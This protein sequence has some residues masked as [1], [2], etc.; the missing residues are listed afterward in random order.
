MVYVCNPRTWEVE[1]RGLGVQGQLQTHIEFEASL[2]YMEPHQSKTKAQISHTNHTQ[3]NCCFL[4]IQL[5]INKTK[6]N[7]CRCLYVCKGLLP[8][9]G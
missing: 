8:C 5:E 6:Q 9:L 7:P 1:A 3:T 2:R 4:G